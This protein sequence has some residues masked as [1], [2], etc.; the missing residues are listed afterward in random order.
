M[1]PKQVWKVAPTPSASILLAS[2]PLTGNPTSLFVINNLREPRNLAVFHDPS[3]SQKYHRLHVSDGIQDIVVEAE[4]RNES[5]KFQC[6]IDSLGHQSQY[7][8]AAIVSF[9]GLLGA[10]QYP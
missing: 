6:V 1:G 10:D 7:Q 9:A 8:F 5:C 2:K 4:K 3:I